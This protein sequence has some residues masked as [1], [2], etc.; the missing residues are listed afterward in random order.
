[1][2]SLS[3]TFIFS[4]AVYLAYGQSAEG[5]T[6][7]ERK[8][9]TVLSEPATLYKGFLQVGYN[10]K[11][12]SPGRLFDNNGDITTPND[13]NYTGDNLD[14]IFRIAYGISDRIQLSVSIPYT[15]S[16][17]EALLQFNETGNQL[18]AIKI[19]VNKKGFTDLQTEAK[20]QLIK[21]SRTFPSIVAGLGAYFPT[22]NNER[23]FTTDPNT[24]D[25]KYDDITG[26]VGTSLLGTLQLRKIMYPYL[27][28]LEFTY[29]KGTDGEIIENGQSIDVIGA[30]SQIWQF[31]AGMHLNEWITFTNKI[32]FQRLSFNS[33]I[34]PNE[35]I[36]IFD[37]SK[38]D[39]LTFDPTLSFQFG[40]IRSEQFISIPVAG[41]NSGAELEYSMSLQYTF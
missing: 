3:L 8:Q 41:K 30:D 16:E 15:N 11:Y 39:L 7:L 12:S 28:S 18:T 13:F 22:G 1:M 35:T 21:E 37:T 36:P 31:V 24:G 26:G 17:L 9:L 29:F 19:D 10:F 25:A 40:R 4:C 6:P 38:K 27:L 34:E 14:H 20:F 2:K 23:S 33:E 5:L 32:Y